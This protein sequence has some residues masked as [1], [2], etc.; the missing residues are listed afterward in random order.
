MTRW[1]MK[2]QEEFYMEILPLPGRI[3]ITHSRFSA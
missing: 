3:E 2:K 1:E